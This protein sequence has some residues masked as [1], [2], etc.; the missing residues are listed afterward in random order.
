MG[1]NTP[2]KYQGY[3]L[4]VTV[5][6]LWILY[7]NIGPDHFAVTNVF[8]PQTSQDSKLQDWTIFFHQN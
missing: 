6:P 1:W 3:S 5:M 8:Q 7:R 4:G 2:K